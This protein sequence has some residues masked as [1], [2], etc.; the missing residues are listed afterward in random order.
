[1][2]GKTSQL[3]CKVVCGTI[4]KG[5]ILG[6]S[7]ITFPMPVHSSLTPANPCTVSFPHSTLWWAQM[8][9]P[10]PDCSHKSKINPPEELHMFKKDT[11]KYFAI[12][13]VLKYAYQL[14]AGK[15]DQQ[16]WFIWKHLAVPTSGTLLLILLQCCTY[17]FCRLLTNC[18][19][20]LQGQWFSSLIYNVGTTFL[21]NPLYCNQSPT[22]SCLTEELQLAASLGLHPTWD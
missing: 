4:H 8:S 1:M 19:K 10:S 20:A 15:S 18:T 11:K 9:V 5:N 16:I 3:H 17:T 21:R 13:N 7:K 12:K 14:S 2:P 22:S 6:C